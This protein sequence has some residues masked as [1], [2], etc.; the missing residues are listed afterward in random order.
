MNTNIKNTIVTTG[1]T[2]FSLGYYRGCQLYYHF[3]I[4]DKNAN[5]GLKEFGLCNILG[6]ING[7]IYVNP[8]FVGFA[9]CDEYQKYKIRTDKDFDE[10]FDENKYFT[11]KYFQFIKK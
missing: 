10:K 7:S 2:M 3:E 6:I 5:F 4:K 8:S 11:N 1:I 9:L